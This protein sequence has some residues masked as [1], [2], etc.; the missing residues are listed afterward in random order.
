MSPGRPKNEPDP[1]DTADA[2]MLALAGGKLSSKK[3]AELETLVKA[4]PDDMVSRIKLL[5]YYS[6]RQFGDKNA[7][8]ERIKHIL[9]FIDFCPECPIDS[10]TQMVG[11]DQ[12]AYDMVKARWLKQLDQDRPLVLDHAATFFIHNDKELA[13]SLYKR[14][15]A[16]EP[17]NPKWPTKLSHLYSL[18]KRTEKSLDA[19]VESMEKETCDTGIFYRMSDLAELQFEVGQIETAEKTSRDLLVMAARFQ[20]D[21]NYGNAVHYANVVLGRI[22]LARDDVQGAT[23]FLLAA[24]DTPG[25]PQLNSFGPSFKLARELL[26][27]NQREAVVEYLKRCQIFWKSGQ[28]ELSSWLDQ[29]SQGK[30]PELPR[31]R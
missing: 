18:W 2:V 4:N 3:A 1:M 7:A 30:C 24:G 25:S 14:A 19:L 10:W 27:R 21:W 26:S 8:Q 22:A 12:S 15:A 11:S 28:K 29:L 16:I 20:G 9:W 23:D 31:H 6:G 5:G 17:A 13:E